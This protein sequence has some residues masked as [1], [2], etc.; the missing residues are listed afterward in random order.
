MEMNFWDYDKYLLHLDHTFLTLLLNFDFWVYHWSLASPFIGFKAIFSTLGCLSFVSTLVLL[1]CTLVVSYL[2][3]TPTKDF[4]IITCLRLRDQGCTHTPL[5][6]QDFSC[7]ANNYTMIICHEAAEQQ[8]ISEAYHCSYSMFFKND[9]LYNYDWCLRSLF[10]LYWKNKL[11]FFM[12]LIKFK[13]I[14]IWSNVIP[15]ETL[16]QIKP[17]HLRKYEYGYLFNINSL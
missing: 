7:K 14:H 15:K 16:S 5:H 17:Q 12:Q 9:Y 6:Q 8:R 3:L 2:P 10:S 1:V 4:F 11:R 13:Q